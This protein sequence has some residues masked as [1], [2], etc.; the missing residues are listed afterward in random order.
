M[1]QSR[2]PKAAKSENL[3]IVT[4]SLLLFHWHE[5]R[6]RDYSGINN[7]APFLP[8]YDIWRQLDIPS[9]TKSFHLPTEWRCPFPSAF[10][11]LKQYL[12]GILS[13][14]ERFYLGSVS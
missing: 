13:K 9:K 2:K 1:H 5:H 8:P 4:N 11:R 10:R 12:R 14:L 7:S 6:L 3:K